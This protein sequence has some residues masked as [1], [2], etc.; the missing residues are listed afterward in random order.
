MSLFLCLEK[1][2]YPASEGAALALHDHLSKVVILHKDATTHSDEDTND[3]K[4][5]AQ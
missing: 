5:I 1:A 2:L 4:K 3:E